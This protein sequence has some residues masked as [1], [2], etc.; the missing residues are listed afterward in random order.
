MFLML[1]RLG[2]ITGSNLKFI[3]DIGLIPDFMNFSSYLERD[4]GIEPVSLPW[5]GS[6][7]PLN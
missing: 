3:W 5:E 4:T 7:E 1:L 2:T 6:I